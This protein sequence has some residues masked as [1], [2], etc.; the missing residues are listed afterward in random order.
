LLRRTARRVGRRAEARSSASTSASASASPLTLLSSGDGQQQARAK[1][2][3]TPS[4]K[5]ALRGNPF[6]Q[7]ARRQNTTAHYTAENRAR[8]SS[9]TRTVAL[10][11]P[12]AAVRGQCG[13]AR[14]RGGSSAR[15]AR[16]YTAGAASVPHTARLRRPVAL[17]AVCCAL[18]VVFFCPTSALRHLSSLG[19]LTMPAH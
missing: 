9:V 11:P 5:V 14:A 3:A 16:T 15:H 1:R 12:R 6:A 19:S 8:A 4:L 10:A 2:R 17:C 18:R 13:G 7:S